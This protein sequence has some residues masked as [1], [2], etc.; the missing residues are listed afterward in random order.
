MR[1]VSVV[2]MKGGVGKTT[3]STGLAETLSARRGQRVLALDLD[4]QASFT[5][6]LLGESGF[7]EMRDA[8]RHTY[9][10]MGELLPGRRADPAPTREFIMGGASRLEPRPK[11][12]VIGAIPLLQKLEREVIYELARSGLARAAIEAHAAEHLREC[13]RE[14]RE[15]YEIVIIDCPPGISAFTEA[16][17]RVS[18]VVLA[19]AVP[20]YLPI[21]GLE[22]F[23]LQMIKPLRSQGAFQG[24]PYVIFNRV[25]GRSEQRRFIDMVGD[26][27]G[28]LGDDLAVFETRLPQDASI[29][30]ATEAR[31][32]PVSYLDKYA[33][34]APIFEDLADELLEELAQLPVAHAIS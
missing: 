7:E 33:K 14:V 15:A 32:L 11:L 24:R 9:R 22:A 23:I 13:L 8:L 26:I 10:L 17:I 25:Q 21:L 27:A 6:A 3:I 5:F 19:P 30:A 12:D 16:A 18:D 2:N 20:E 34:A 29:A 4:A 31:E 28:D 1:V